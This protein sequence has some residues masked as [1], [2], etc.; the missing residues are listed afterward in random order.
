MA[1]AMTSAPSRSSAAIT[2]R[3]TTP[4]PAS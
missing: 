2:A 3:A 4:T 1:R